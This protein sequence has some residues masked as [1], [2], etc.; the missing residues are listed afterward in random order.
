MR[1]KRPHVAVLDELKIVRKDQYAKIEYSDPTV[2]GVTLNLGPEVQ[3]LTDQEIVNRLNDVIQAQENMAADYKY[4]AVEIPEG[5]PQIRYSEDCDQ[6][7]PR[8]GVLRCEISDGGP[9]AE[10]TVIIDENEFSLCEFGRL[11]STY[12]GWGMRIEFV[13]DDSTSNRPTIEVRNKTDDNT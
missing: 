8:G 12:N 4:V 3:N 11:L 9:N 7:V 13:P 1:K 10:T 6:W 5:Y 2:A